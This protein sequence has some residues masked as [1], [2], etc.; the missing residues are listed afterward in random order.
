[1]NLIAHQKV[2]E[3]FFK[4]LPQTSLFIGPYS[5][6]KWT[7]AE[8]VRQ[9]LQVQP[10]DVLRIKM[11]TADALRGYVRFASVAPV[12]KVKLAIIRYSSANLDFILKTLEEPKPGVYTIL[13]SDKSPK[14]TIR[15]RLRVFQFPLLSSSQV[16]Q[17]LTEVKGFKP[18][19]ASRLSLLS[20]GHVAKA[21]RAAQSDVP[22]LPV[23]SLLEAVATRD[24]A[25]LET[26]ANRWTDETTDL[27][28]VWCHEAI[29][30]QWSIF[31]E[32]ESLIEGK[33]IPLKLLA[34]IR[35]NVRPKLL[36]RANIIE[37]VKGLQ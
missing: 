5:V 11:S 18:D 3:E 31:S 29:T 26:L 25:R 6:G 15:S 10:A 17:V 36:V 14:A 1:M 24:T 7:A 2:V 16:A 32:E 28:A 9:R 33:G 8:V 19:S 35:A 12:G 37:L 21:L 4:E 30:G 23:L 34:T 20:G 13:V 27:L 22:K